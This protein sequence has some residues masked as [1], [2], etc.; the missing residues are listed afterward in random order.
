M[1][2]TGLN[3]LFKDEKSV[4]VAEYSIIISHI[5]CLAGLFLALSAFNPRSAE[6]C[7]LNVSSGITSASARE[8]Q[9]SLHCIHVSNPLCT[10]IGCLNEFYA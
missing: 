10:L 1:M 7:A 9:D 2:T 8:N 4:A 3:R 5:G 6:V